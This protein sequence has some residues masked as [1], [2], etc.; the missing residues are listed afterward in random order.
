MASWQTVCRKRT[1]AKSSNGPHSSLQPKF[2]PHFSSHELLRLLDKDDNAIVFELSN[3]IKRFQVTLKDSDICTRYLGLVLELLLKVSSGLA[4]DSE[5]HSSSVMI[6][7]EVF[8]DRCSTFQCQL[9]IYVAKTIIEQP[10]IEKSIETICKFFEILLSKLPETCWSILPIDQLYETISLLET[11]GDLAKGHDFLLKVKDLLEQ[12]EGIKEQQQIVRIVGSRSSI[13]RQKRWDNTEY[14]SIPII[15]QWHEIRS[16]KRPFKLRP[17]I[18]DGE[19]EDWMHYYDVQFRL[20]REDFI[21]PL[22]LGIKDFHNGKKGRNLSNLRRYENVTIVKPVFTEA[23]LCHVIKF[24]LKYMKCNWEHSKKLIYGSLLCLSPD[25][26]EHTVLFATVSNREVH[27]GKCRIQVMFQRGTEGMTHQRCGTKFVMVE[28]IAFFEASRHILR[29]LQTAEVS[30]MPFTSYLIKNDGE[31]VHPPKY[32]EFGHP[33]TTY[34]M[35]SIIKDEILSKPKLAFKFSRID[36]RKIQQWPP[37]EDTILDESQ[38]MAM[39]M[40]LTQEIAVIQGPPGTGKTFIGLKIVQALLKN[41]SA[42]NSTRFGSTNNLLRS[43]I[44]VMCLT[45]H[46]LDQFLEGIMELDRDE[47]L[48]LIRI[49]GRSK[50]E[51]LADCN[52]KIVK[53]NLKNIPKSDYVAM[54]ELAAEVKQVGVECNYRLQ[55]YRDPSHDFIP[56][57]DIQVVIREY[58]IRSLQDPTVSVEEEEFALE[59]WLGLYVKEEY[60]MIIPI[61]SMEECFQE[62]LTSS[63][64]E[65]EECESEYEDNEY[66]SANSDFDD[67]EEWEIAD[68]TRGQETIDIIDEGKREE[69]ARMIAGMEENYRELSFDNP[70]IATKKKVKRTHNIRRMVKIKKC[71]NFRKLLKIQM[72]SCAM[73]E[74]DADEIED[75]NQ[76]DLDKRWEL[77]M[78]WHAK[79]RS[80]LLQDLEEECQRYNRACEQADK[81][82][83]DVDRFA[84]ETAHVIGMTTTGAAKYQHILHIMK[85]RIVIVEEAAEVLESHIVS[86]LNAGTQHLI[87]IGDHKQ[88]RPKPNDYDLAVNYNLEV[89]LFERLVRNNFPHATLHNQHR[90]RPEIAELVK[91]HIYDTLYNHDSV[92]HYPNVRGV[93]SNIFLIQHNEPEQPSSDLSHS[94]N[95]EKDYLIAL[96]KYLLKQGHKCAQI[97]ILVTYTGQLLLMKNSMLKS[98]FQGIRI[99]TVDDFQGEENDIILLSLVRSNKEGIIGFLKEENRVCVAL[100]RAKHGFYCIGNFEM[101]RKNSS[102]W[103]S[104]VSDMESKDRVGDGLK[105]CCTNHPKNEFLAKSPEDFIKNSPLGGC[106]LDCDIRLKC[107]HTCPRKCHLSDLKHLKYPCTKTCGKACPEGHRCNRPCYEECQ[108]RVRVKKEM[109]KCQHIQEMYCYENPAKISC[110]FMLEKTIPLCGHSWEMHCHQNPAHFS[111]ALV[112]EKTIPECEHTHSMPCHNSLKGFMCPTRITKV[113][114]ECSHTKELPCHQSPKLAKC[115]TVVS[116][117]LLCKHTHEMPCHQNPVMFWCP[118]DVVKLLPRCGHSKEMPCHQ[119]PISVRCQTD[120]VKLIPRCGH[121][122]KMPCHQ[123]PMNVQC[124][125]TCKKPCPKGH[126]CQHQCHHQIKCQPCKSIVIVKL[127]NCGHEERA[128]CHQDLAQLKCSAKCSKECKRGHPCPLNCHEECQDCKVIVH[129]PMKCGHSASVKC[130]ELEHYVCTE[131]VNRTLSCGHSITMSCSVDIN[132]IAC[133]YM[134]DLTLKECRHTISVP[135][136]SDV[137][138]INCKALVD[139]FLKCHHSIAVPCSTDRHTNIIQCMEVCSKILKCGHRKNLKCYEDTGSVTCTK[140][141]NKN[142]SCGHT[143]KVACFEEVSSSSCVERCTKDLPCG[144]STTA[145]CNRDP[146]SITCQ[147]P[148]T[149]TLKCGHQCHAICGTDCACSES[150]KVTLPI[151]GHIENVLCSQKNHLQNYLCKKSCNKSLPCGHKCRNLCGRSCSKICMEIVKSVCSQKHK[152]SVQ[153][154]QMNSLGPCEQACEKVLDCGHSCKK[155]C[156]EPCTTKCNYISVKTY[157]C[158]HKQRLPCYLPIEKVLCDYRCRLPLACGHFCRGKCSDCSTTRIHKL[159]TSTVS[160]KHYCGE[161]TRMSCLGL[162]NKH[163]SSSSKSEQFSQVLECEHRKIPWNCSMPLLHCQEACGWACPPQ[164]KH[165]KKCTKSCSEMCDRE[166]CNERCTKILS[167]GHHCVGLCGEPCVSLCPRCSPEDF[168]TQHKEVREFSENEHYTQLACSHIFTVTE[169]DKHVD[170]APDSEV[171][172]LQCPSCSC[173]LSSTFR[174]GNQMKESL[175]HVEAVSKEVKVRRREKAPLVKLYADKAIVQK[176]TRPNMKILMDGLNPKKEFLFFV[177]AKVHSLVTSSDPSMKINMT[178]EEL[179]SWIQ[180]NLENARLSYQVINDL[181]SEYFRLCLQVR[182]LDRHRYRTGNVTELMSFLAKLDTDCSLRVTRRDFIYHSRLLDDC[183][184]EPVPSNFQCTDEVLKEVDYFQPMIK[185][186][187]WRKCLHDHYYCVPV[188]EP[189]CL[190]VQC[191]ECIGQ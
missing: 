64:G 79:Y 137:C 72:K 113:I 51:K 10:N 122:K 164:C 171:C 97:T 133:P 80:L 139:V 55:R 61:E 145:E 52:L 88:L 114:P 57:S 41:F 93:T 43:P 130:S 94:N 31:H 178:I 56:F 70:I 181:L 62:E 154:F 159:C 40:A 58:N 47:K 141:C 28:S 138:K 12:R 27:C 125:N 99:S 37:L 81:A 167:C 111:C 83:H 118:T 180:R 103:Q 73:E 127:P 16:S 92:H 183:I 26:F 38:L 163:S 25:N 187:L 50:S 39:R 89:S 190:K 34:N 166:P 96:C 112:V 45:N 179:S 162:T 119:D 87:L 86:A 110:K 160:V 60:E 115:D 176:L 76:L 157:P 121:S 32:L 53:K 105:L 126:P 17:N 91:P 100:S 143:K 2:C 5:I 21:S 165:P 177:F 95:H 77:Y 75:V 191:S 42:W 156:F 20:L 84:L 129:L 11:T 182:I 128:A 18:V 173:F 49:G 108:C 151:C 107:G 69:E 33:G 184:R 117:R 63:E 161:K 1:N 66:Y 6:L 153:C 85:P 19:Y 4:C 14:R 24:D 102:V 44:L 150:V 9:K 29:S 168:S 136:S 147:K 172:P 140:P 78:H 186:G 170:R 54:K 35:S 74:I 90:M 116:K 46:A 120:V 36:I 106:L 146:S 30:T 23:G 175:L 3:E 7:G 13:A 134:I 48:K 71:D 188:S 169:M 135:C 185:N 22:R 82:K 67:E 8:N 144:H 98:E 174:Y 189:Y 104:I 59:L 155:M 142:L 152:R 123:D 124:W 101:L 15:P 109:P 148:C 131:M 158:G 68:D 149:K 132:S 65:S